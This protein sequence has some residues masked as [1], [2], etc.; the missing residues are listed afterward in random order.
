MYL[1]K[2]Y[3]LITVPIDQMDTLQERYALYYETFGKFT[4]VTDK[5]TTVCII[6]SC[7]IAVAVFVMFCISVSRSENKRLQ[8]QGELIKP[9]V[10]VL[11]LTPQALFGL[12]Y[13]VLQLVAG[14][15][16]EDVRYRFIDTVTTV[17]SWAL[18]LTVF[19]CVLF[20]LIFG[21]ILKKKPSVSEQVPEPAPQQE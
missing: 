15:L 3:M 14:F 9:V 21:V 8:F 16:S 18:Y 10:S 12:R 7:V 11:I 6:I 2:K 17:Y 5:I 20:I 4:D 19:V 13:F 1:L